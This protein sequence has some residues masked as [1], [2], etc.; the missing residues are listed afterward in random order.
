M[1]LVL[2]QSPNALLESQETLVDF[3]SVHPGLLVGLDRIGASFVS[4][5]IY[6]GK[7]PDEVLLVLESDLKDGV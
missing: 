2:V 4:S 1:A 7:L 3:G 6:E 5:Q